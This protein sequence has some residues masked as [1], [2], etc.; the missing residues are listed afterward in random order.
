MSTLQKIGVWTLM[1][2]GLF[3][4]SDFLI[5]IGLNSTYQD[6]KRLDENTD[7]IIYQA[8]ATYVNGRIRGLLNKEQEIQGKYLKVELYSK[9]DVLVG[10]K[11][12][13]IE[14]LLVDDTKP[15]EI[16]FKAKDA[17]QFKMEIVNEKEEGKELEIIPRELTKPEII[18]TAAFMF[19]IFW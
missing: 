15:F 17:S 14:T 19:L 8:D 16:L 6:M 13:E 10:K 18:L 9:R 7:I 5:A 3:I 4:L 12:I 1:L 11:F 2:I